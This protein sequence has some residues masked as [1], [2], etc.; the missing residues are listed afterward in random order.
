MYR[1]SGSLIII[2]SPRQ[3]NGIS[4]DQAGQKSL[5]LPLSYR[6]SSTTLI[7]CRS[8]M[9]NGIYDSTQKPPWWLF[10]LNPFCPYRVHYAPLS[11]TAGVLMKERQCTGRGRLTHICSPFNC[12]SSEV[13]KS[14][15]TPH[16]VN[17]L[18]KRQCQIS[19]PHR[20]WLILL[21]HR[22]WLNILPHPSI[23]NELIIR[24]QSFGCQRE[25][26]KRLSIFR[27]ELQDRFNCL[28]SHSL[29]A[30]MRFYPRSPK[31]HILHSV[32]F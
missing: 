22:K 21:A 11:P 7:F 26:Q 5:V 9:A 1:R 19:L 16:Q 18:P 17:L 27:S 24:C 29:C 6:F 15:L 3:R 32:I 8:V 12:R 13:I 25:R 28:R 4:L 2:G 14:I 20:R 23:I 10:S 31:P 30:N